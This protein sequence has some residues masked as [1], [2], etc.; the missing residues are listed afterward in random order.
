MKNKG[1]DLREERLI[2]EFL[3]EYQDEELPAELRVRVLKNL[4]QS[5]D[6]T[7]IKIITPMWKRLSLAAS[8]IAFALGIIMSNQVFS[9]DNTSEYANWNF[10][11]A[12]LYSYLVEGE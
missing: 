6:K 2:T 9:S 10:G 12:G 11:E 5:S 7:V 8:I 3:S 4:V 1:K